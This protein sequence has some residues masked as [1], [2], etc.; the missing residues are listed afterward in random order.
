MKST[1]TGLYAVAILSILSLGCFFNTSTTNVKGKVVHSKKPVEG[2]EVSFG[3]TGGKVTMITGPDG[4]F[5]LTV[6]HRPTVILY[7]EAKKGTL[8]QSEPLEFPGFMAPDNPRTIEML[9]TFAP[10]KR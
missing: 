5:D 4:A 3:P 8:A 1:K 6:N 9:T 7:L 10:T 2:A